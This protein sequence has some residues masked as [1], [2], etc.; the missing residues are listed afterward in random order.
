M[1]FDI[2]SQELQRDKDGGVSEYCAW[3][4]ASVNLRQTVYMVHRHREVLRCCAA[5]VAGWRDE[6]KIRLK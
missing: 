6:D 1:N 3:V 5:A 4:H 2:E